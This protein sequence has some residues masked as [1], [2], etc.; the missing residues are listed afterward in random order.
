[1]SFALLHGSSLQ[2]SSTLEDSLPPSEVH[3]V[4]VKPSPAIGV[5]AEPETTVQGTE[6]ML[7]S[8]G[9]V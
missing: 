6:F 3:I 7:A 9:Q 4:G 2:V 8:E 5:L 1:M